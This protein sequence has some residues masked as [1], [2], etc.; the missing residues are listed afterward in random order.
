MH[1]ETEGIPMGAFKKNFTLKNQF[2]EILP[3]I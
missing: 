2:S 1:S 3:K